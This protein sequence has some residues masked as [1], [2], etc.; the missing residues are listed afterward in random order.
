MMLGSIATDYGND[1]V[2]KALHINPHVGKMERY[3]QARSKRVGRSHCPQ[4]S[5]HWKNSGRKFQTLER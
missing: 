1:S 3:H 5:K 4:F 2:L